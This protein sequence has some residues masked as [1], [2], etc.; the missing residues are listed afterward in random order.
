MDKSR[1]A[2][3]PF[4]GEDSLEALKR[5]ALIVDN[6]T[7]AFLTSIPRARRARFPLSVAYYSEE[8]IRRVSTELEWLFDNG[9]LNS[10]KDNPFATGWEME[11]FNRD[12][13]VWVIRTT[14]STHYF[15]PD[16][17][18]I[19][20]D[21]SEITRSELLIENTPELTIADIRNP[22]HDVPII[23]SSGSLLRN[24]LKNTPRNNKSLVLDLV[25]SSVPQPTNETP[26][27]AIIDWRNDEEAKMKFRRLKNWMNKA[28]DKKDLNPVHLKDEILHLLDEYQQYMKIQNAKFSQ[29][30][31]RTIVTTTAEVVESLA[32]LKI[33]SLAEMPFK[34]SEANIAVQEAEL[35]APGRDLAY[36][37]DA[38]RR[39]K[40]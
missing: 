20:D 31:L 29:G 16:H 6:V 34:I 18:P 17:N 39:F 1:T 35:K 40:H 3:L 19:E 5:S 36:I 15:Q 4:T 12:L 2:L 13:P 32:K 38:Q 22:L 25:L 28:S 8:Q 37:V 10:P 26:W 21:L 24:K 33:K 7:L 9:L 14:S 27:E 30:T 23:L 11:D